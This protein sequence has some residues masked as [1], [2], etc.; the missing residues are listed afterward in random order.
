MLVGSC[1]STLVS[2]TKSLGK[3]VLAV[4]LT[5]GA[6]RRLRSTMGLLGFQWR[7]VVDMLARSTRETQ[8]MVVGYML[9]PYGLWRIGNKG[10]ASLQSLHC[11]EHFLGVARDLDPAPLLD[12]RAFGVDQERAAL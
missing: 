8:E 11:L 4:L 9:C 10:L 12:E 2:S 3:E 6:R 1:I 5:W 7:R